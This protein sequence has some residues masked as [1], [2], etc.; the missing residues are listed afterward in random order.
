MFS[1]RALFREEGF[2]TGGSAMTFL[3]GLLATYASLE[4]LNRFGLKLADTMRGRARLA[5]GI[6]FIISGGY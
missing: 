4:L 6:M 5:I 2:L 3:I 1:F